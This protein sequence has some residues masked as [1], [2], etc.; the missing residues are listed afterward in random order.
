[1]SIW[2]RRHW[3]LV[4]VQVL[5]SC[6]RERPAGE[7]AKPPESPSQTAVAE[8]ARGTSATEAPACKE[9]PT[10][11]SLSRSGLGPI[12]LGAPVEAV[13]EICPLARDSVDEQWGALIIIPTPTG[14]IAVRPDPI[15][16]HAPAT[17]HVRE[18]SIETPAIR[19]SGE[20]GVG[21]SL[22]D[23]RRVFGSVLVLLIPEYGYYALPRG[24]DK[25]VAF[26]LEGIPSNV[27]DWTEAD[28]ARNSDQVPGTATIVALEVALRD[29]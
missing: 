27:V 19:V 14:R 13:R 28:S 22:A 12:R 17:G 3:L 23:V 2:K 11:W 26:R 1:M 20:L 5:W 4:A 8:T 24:P 7:A 16:S 15:A 6:K 10:T 9:D 18:I 29:R 21:S 25:W